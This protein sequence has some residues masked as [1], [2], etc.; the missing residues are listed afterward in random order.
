MD[1]T[2][3]GSLVIGG[4]NLL[5]GLL[6]YSGAQRANQANI[7]LGREQREWQQW[8]TGQAHQ[9]EVNDLKA[10]GLN[11]ILSVNAGANTPS[12]GLPQ[13]S[14]AMEPLGS[15][16]ASGAKEALGFKLAA[17]KQ[18][19]EIELLKAQKLAVKADEQQKTNA[20]NELAARTNILNYQMPSIKKQADYDYKFGDVDAYGK[21]IQM[22]S[23]ILGKLLNR[24]QFNAPKTDKP[25]DPYNLGPQK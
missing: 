13:V 14:N 7:D 3:A 20:A 17:A 22:G 8:M 23:D 16:L 5:G 10:A 4:S 12:P 18:K 19:E 1:P 15:A 9:I 21:R 25:L 6:G 11:P 24:F 2:L